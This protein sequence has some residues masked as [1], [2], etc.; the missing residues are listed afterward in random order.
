MCLSKKCLRIVKELWKRRQFT[1]DKS[2][3]ERIKEYQ[4]ISKTSL[5]RFI[6]EHCDITDSEAYMPFDD[7]YVDYIIYLKKNNKESPSKISISKE[8]RRLGYEIKMKGY[9]NSQTILSDDVG[10]WVTK[11]SII[12]IKLKKEKN[13]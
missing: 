7:F 12:G 2:I 8:L 10:N 3:S 1:G 5:E 6:D 13:E 4:I 9:K 11:M